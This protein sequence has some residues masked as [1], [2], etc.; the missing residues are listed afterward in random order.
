MRDP[1]RT[2]I[3]DFRT[4]QSP[5]D[6]AKT[7]VRDK[8][9]EPVS[10]TGQKFYP[11]YFLE[12][13]Q[14]YAIWSK[15]SSQVSGGKRY[16]V[17]DSSASKSCQVRVDMRQVRIDSGLRRI[18][19]GIWWMQ[20]PH[21]AW[22]QSSY[23]QDW[24]NMVGKINHMICK[25]SGLCYEL[26]WIHTRRSHKWALWS[27][28]WRQSLHSLKPWERAS[29]QPQMHQVYCSL[30]SSKLNFTPRFTAFFVAWI[31]Y[32]SDQKMTSSLKGLA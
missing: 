20:S 16:E 9:P 28:D 17:Q 6:Y 23:F 7:E 18:V 14:R 2:E 24:F 8:L 4:M 31:W 29:K 1:E 32:T 25:I 12:F 26:N 21:G 19:F 11:L 5:K 10:Y 3:N 13:F 15:Q 27:K 30:Q 22:L